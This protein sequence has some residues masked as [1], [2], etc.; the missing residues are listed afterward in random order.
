MNSILLL[1]AAFSA[2]GHLHQAG[3]SEIMF[4]NKEECKQYVQLTTEAN[5]YAYYA[6]EYVENNF[7]IYTA[8]NSFLVASCLGENEEPIL[9]TGVVETIE[10][11][12]I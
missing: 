5:P 11:E 3:Y 7:K 6:E 8:D 9:P 2:E 1:L 10:E 4:Q 12:Y